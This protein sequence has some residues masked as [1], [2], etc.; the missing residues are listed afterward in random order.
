LNICTLNREGGGRNERKTVDNGNVTLQTQEEKKK[1]GGLTPG[2][3]ISR[4]CVSKN[5]NKVTQVA[6]GERKN[7]WGGWSISRKPEP[8]ISDKNPMREPQSQN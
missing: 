7:L 4:L 1:E 2:S 6:C 8:V 5:T 3:G